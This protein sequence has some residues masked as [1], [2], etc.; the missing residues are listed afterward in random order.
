MLTWQ[1]LFKPASTTLFAI[2]GRGRRLET[3][4]ARRESMADAKIELYPTETLSNYH[5]SKHASK[6]HC[7]C[8]AQ[9]RWVSRGLHRKA[10]SRSVAADSPKVLCYQFIR[11][12]LIPDYTYVLPYDGRRPIGSDEVFLLFR[13]TMHIDPAIWGADARE[14]KPERWL[15]DE[16]RSKEK[17]WLVVSGI[18]FFFQ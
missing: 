13:S 2:Q 1:L 3:R 18:N 5:I 15:D 4:S 17:C 16:I 8:L 10:A 7:E 14:F 11:S 6:N 9:T 12:K